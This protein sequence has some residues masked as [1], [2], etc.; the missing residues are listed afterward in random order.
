MQKGSSRKCGKRTKTEA[1][2]SREEWRA[3]LRARV[4]GFEVVGRA[5]VRRERGGGAASSP[6]VSRWQ[7]SN[8]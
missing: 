2:R 3:E 7:G 4:P 6:E 1:A 8:R 5:S